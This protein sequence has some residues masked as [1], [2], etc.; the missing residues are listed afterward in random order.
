[1]RP[2]PHGRTVHKGAP[3]DGWACRQLAP[4]EAR[5]AVYGGPHPRPVR[6]NRAPGHDGP[7]RY[8]R[9]ADFLVLAEWTDA[10]VPSA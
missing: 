9:A 8:T 3:A 1:M 6:C 2:G 4:P 5:A 10:E 7:H